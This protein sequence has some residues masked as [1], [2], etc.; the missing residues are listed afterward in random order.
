MSHRSSFADMKAEQ[1]RMTA[2][3]KAEGRQSEPWAVADP[4]M[5]RF[6]RQV[7][8]SV[9]KWAAAMTAILYIPRMNGAKL[10]AR[11]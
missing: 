3:W 5:S 6:L 10:C 7:S 4:E 11:L 1:G 2:S 8:P 9:W